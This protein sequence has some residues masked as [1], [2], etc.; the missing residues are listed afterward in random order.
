MEGGTGG[1]FSCE[2]LVAWIS[3]T[4]DHPGSA[5]LTSVGGVVV[6]ISSS[7]LEIAIRIFV[8]I[9]CLFSMIVVHLPV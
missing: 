9:P 4:V 7:Q 8:A 1:G 6:D 5:A 3:R 2:S